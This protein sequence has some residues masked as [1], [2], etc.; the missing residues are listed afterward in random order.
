VNIDYLNVQNLVNSAYVLL[1]LC[2]HG[3]W[4]HHIVIHIMCPMVQL[5]KSSVR[6]VL[7]VIVKNTNGWRISVSKLC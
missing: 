1:V 7:Y 4:Y 3:P 2:Q 5:L 6:P